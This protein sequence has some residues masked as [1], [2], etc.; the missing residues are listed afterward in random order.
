MIEITVKTEREA[1]DTARTL[2]RAA[3]IIRG[4]PAV[5][6]IEQTALINSLCVLRDAI[7]V[8]EP[9]KEDYNE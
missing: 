8:K 7:Q 9:T 1:I 3:N 2:T 5:S 4:A 6:D